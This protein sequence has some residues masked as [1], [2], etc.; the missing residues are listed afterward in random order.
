MGLS[1]RT[2]RNVDLSFYEGQVPVNY[3]YTYGLGL[4]KFFR[5]IKDT[6]EFLASRCPECGAVYFPCRVFCEQCFAAIPRTFKVPGTG[7]VFSFT[8]C[9]LG[10]KGESKKKPDAVGLIEMDGAEGAK[11]VH[12]LD[13]KPENLKIGMKVKAVLKPKKDR[14]GEIFDIK[15]FAKA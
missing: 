1:E 11:F 8:L 12:L 7:T 3:V 2:E 5:A 4:E 6:G 13:V 10:M 14:R 9:H 15:G